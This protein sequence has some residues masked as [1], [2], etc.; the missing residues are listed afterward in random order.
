MKGR[1]GSNPALSAIESFS[2]CN[3]ATDDRNTRVCGGFAHAGGGGERPR[4]LRISLR[5]PTRSKMSD[6]GL[7]CLDPSPRSDE[8]SSETGGRGAQGPDGFLGTERAKDL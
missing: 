8:K 6:S 4:A 5:S 1:Y 3:P 2:V 7:A